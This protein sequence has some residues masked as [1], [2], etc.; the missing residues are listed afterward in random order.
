[1]NQVSG[2][3]RIGWESYFSPL[4]Q[5]VLDIERREHS[6]ESLEV[7]KERS[8]TKL[9]RN[10]GGITGGTIKIQYCEIRKNVPNI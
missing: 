2:G 1:M 3:T 9:L 5:L 4:E 8:L 6:S 10:A 7:L